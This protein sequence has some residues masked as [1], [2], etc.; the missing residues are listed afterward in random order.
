VKNVNRKKAL[1]ISATYLAVAILL[2]PTILFVGSYLIYAP[3][4]SATFQQYASYV[5][6][7]FI[8]ALFVGLLVLAGYLL[9]LGYKKI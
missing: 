6:L 7:M 9:F 3:Y 1:Y 4:F 5:G 2:V 8:P